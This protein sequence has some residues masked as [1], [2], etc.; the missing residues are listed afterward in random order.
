MMKSEEFAKNIMDQVADRRLTPRPRWAF[1]LADA[2]LWS[3]A[4][5]T[6][7][8]GALAVAVVIFILTDHDWDI[9]RYLDRGPIEHFF[10]SLP[11]F[12]IA[13]LLLF[14][15]L[16]RYNFRHTRRGYRYETWAVA[17][18]SVA[19][20][21]V[22]G[23]VMYAA[24]LGQELHEY[25]SEALPLYERLVYTK[26]DIWIFPEKGLLSGLIDGLDDDHGFTLIDFRGREW[27]VL[28]GPNIVWERNLQPAVGLRVK[29][30]GVQD[31]AGVFTA[32][33]VRPWSR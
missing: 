4:A 5:L 15:L 24:G 12:W 14:A 10:V 22:V 27:R 17:A 26:N 20:S 6:T 9:Y 23:G 33:I 32:E 18:G 28:N 11:Y 8:L 25:F 7:A 29:L 30:I 13:F 16:A 31:G 2:V 21:L 3:A 19:A 1:L